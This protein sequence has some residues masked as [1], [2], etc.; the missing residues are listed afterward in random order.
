MSQPGVS[1]LV[2]GYLRRLLII[3]IKNP[4]PNYAAIHRGRGR[5]RSQDFQHRTGAIQAL[6]SGGRY[7]SHHPD[8]VALRIKCIDQRLD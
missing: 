2:G 7:K 3:F 6:G 8:Q 1:N 4:D 5:Q